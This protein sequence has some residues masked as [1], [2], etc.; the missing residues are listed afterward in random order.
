MNI[1]ALGPRRSMRGRKP[2]SDTFDDYDQSINEVINL[3]L[4]HFFVLFS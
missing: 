3:F 1:N 4:W 2:V